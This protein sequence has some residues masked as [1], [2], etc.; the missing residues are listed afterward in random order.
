MIAEQTVELNIDLEQA[1]RCESRHD[2][3]RMVGLDLPC[4]VA[5]TWIGVGD[6]GHSMLLCDIA[7][8]A[9]DL[10]ETL[11]WVGWTCNTCGTKHTHEIRRPL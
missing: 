4:R 2:A 7:K 5:A 11:S 9:H 1:P 8:V 3:D 10:W 6:C